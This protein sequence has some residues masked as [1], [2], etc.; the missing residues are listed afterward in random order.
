MN[1][2]LSIFTGQDLAVTG[3][4]ASESPMNKKRLAGQNYRLLKYLCEIKTIHC[5]SPAI[6]ELKIGMLHSRISD[7]KNKHGIDVKSKIITV[8]SFFG[9]PVSVKEY[10]LEREEIKRSKERFEV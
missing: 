10:W 7:L 5:F 8:I 4:V 9:E 1:R 3:M 2:Q 6:K